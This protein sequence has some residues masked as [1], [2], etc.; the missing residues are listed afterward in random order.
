MSIAYWVLSNKKA[1]PNTPYS[2]L[3]TTEHGR[4]HLEGENLKKSQGRFDK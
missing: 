2:I 4:Y 1:L 3:N